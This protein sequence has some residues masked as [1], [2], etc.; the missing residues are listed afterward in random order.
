M[1][2]RQIQNRHFIVL[3]RGEEIVDAITHY[4]QEKDLRSGSISAIGAAD[5]VV[6]R[7]YD[8]ATKKYESKTFEGQF[9]IA[10]LLGNISLL[11]GKPWP[12][13][14]ITLTDTDYRAF[15][16]HLQSARVGVTC[17]II[18]DA[19]DTTIERE[20]D[21]ETGLKVWKL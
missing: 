19:T 13:L 20:V 15:G 8:V 7:Y 16:G 14:H 18:I 17:E 1:K 3:Q 21:E 4:V 2:A 6:L 9:E 11:D 12:H 5:Q 10:S